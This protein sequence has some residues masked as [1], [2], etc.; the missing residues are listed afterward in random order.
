MKSTCQE[1]HPSRRPQCTGCLLGAHDAQSHHNHSNDRAEESSSVSHPK[2]WAKL[3]CAK[4]WSEVAA[5]A[6]LA[7]TP[8]PTTI[9]AG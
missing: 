9:P 7:M 3:V 4:N 8:Q 1:E 2:S 5:S 6:M